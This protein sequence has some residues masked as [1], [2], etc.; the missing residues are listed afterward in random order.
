MPCIATKDCW[1]Q[2]LY[3]A[4]VSAIK[5]G[6]GGG[7]KR[8][9]G[10]GVGGEQTSGCLRILVLILMQKSRTKRISCNSQLVAIPLLYKVKLFST[11]SSLLVL[12]LHIGFYTILPSPI[13]YGVWHAEGGRWG[14]TYI[15]QRACNSI[16][17]R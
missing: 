4:I 9:G 3:C 10:D 15:V 14:G 16:A 5:G 12:C 6:G 7:R 2:I 8:W 1:G 17:I 13:V 11:A